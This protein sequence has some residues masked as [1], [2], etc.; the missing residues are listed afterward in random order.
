M[1]FVSSRTPGIV[2]AVAATGY[3]LSA[4]LHAPTLA[5]QERAY[6]PGFRDIVLDRTVSQP[7]PVFGI[8]EASG[9]AS[10]YKPPTGKDLCDA[11]FHDPALPSAGK[12][13]ARVQL[14]TFFDYRCPYCKTLADIIPT[15]N[16]AEVHVA[17]HEWAILGPPS[18]LAARAALAADRQGKYIAVHDRLMRARLVPTIDYIDAVAR[19]LNLEIVRLHRD[20]DSDGIM[21]ALKRT[22]QLATS[23]GFAGTPALVVGHTVAQGEISR[24][25]L[26]QLVVEEGHSAL[27]NAC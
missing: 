7:D 27:P 26:R 1:R 17:Y 2:A 9:E 20:M 6:P 25:Q 11:L 15:M 12:V 4:Y 24:A 18:V 14:A 22:G 3:F 8:P 16:F 19:D 23:F 13:N 10:P 5:F 21:N